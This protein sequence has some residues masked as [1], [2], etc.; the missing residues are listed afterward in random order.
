LKDILMSIVMVLNMVMSIQM[1]YDVKYHKG[2][3]A[4]PTFPGSV[5]STGIFPFR[6]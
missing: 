1:G 2:L 5:K 6:S 4:M 3:P